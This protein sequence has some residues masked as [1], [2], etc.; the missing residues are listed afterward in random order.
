MKKKRK[1]KVRGTPKQ[2]VRGPEK[3]ISPDLMNLVWHIRQA[4][5]EERHH[6]LLHRYGWKR[7][8]NYDVLL[9][10]WPEALRNSI[11]PELAKHAIAGT[12]PEVC[13][14]LEK[15]RGA[16]RKSN[17]RRL[18]IDIIRKLRDEGGGEPPAYK[19]VCLAIVK[20]DPG[21]LEHFICRKDG[22]DWPDSLERYIRRVAKEEGLLLAKLK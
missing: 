5:E 4:Q 15:N 8:H 21:V 19:N 16:S 17:I 22:Q 11:G 13:R 10:I 20:A 12:L 3:P 1:R 18:V 2:R 9:S 6:D 7:G 14:A